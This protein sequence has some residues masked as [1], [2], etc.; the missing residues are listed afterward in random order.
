MMALLWLYETKAPQAHERHLA[1]EVRVEPSLGSHLVEYGTA[2]PGVG[3]QKGLEVTN[4]KH[5]HIH[6]QILQPDPGQ[7]QLTNL[8]LDSKEAEKPLVLS[9]LS[10]VL[11]Q[12]L[13]KPPVLIQPIFRSYNFLDSSLS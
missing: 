7:S 6:I 1:N 12:C 10:M 8:E 3:E 5:T 4:R 2:S 13:L 9:H 11:C